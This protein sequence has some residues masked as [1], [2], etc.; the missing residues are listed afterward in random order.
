LNSNSVQILELKSI[1]VQE[2]SGGG[3]TDIYVLYSFSLLT[4]FSGTGFLSLII[5]VL[6]KF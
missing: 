5:T 6:S 4:A 1:H 3:F 2:A